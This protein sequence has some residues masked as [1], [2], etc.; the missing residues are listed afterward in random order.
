[1]T[2]YLG[3]SKHYS[4]HYENDSISDILVSGHLAGPGIFGCFLS[5]I[6]SAGQIPQKRDESG[7]SHLREA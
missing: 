4:F 3:G 2:T 5:M 1:M 6:P 7:R